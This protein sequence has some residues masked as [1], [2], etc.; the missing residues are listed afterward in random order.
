VTL[1]TRRKALA[2]I[3][4]GS[5]LEYCTRMGRREDDTSSR[6]GSTLDTL[7]VLTCD[8]PHALVRAVRTH[9]EDAAR[10]GGVRRLLIV[11]GGRAADARDASGAMI[12]RASDRAGA[13]I[14]WW[15][16]RARK[17]LATWLARAAGVD[18]RVGR[19]AMLGDGAHGPTHGAG[20]NS[21]LLLCAGRVL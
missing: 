16:R 14:S 10:G 15:D 9:L 20:R 4:A 17:R 3:R 1:R 5:D 8:R 13:R 2:A 18:E 21:I 6:R 11:D 19:F 12:G 7:A